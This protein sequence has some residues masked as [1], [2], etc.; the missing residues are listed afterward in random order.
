MISLIIG[1][2][3]A[4]VV[5][6]LTFKHPEKGP[7]SFGQACLINIAQFVIYIIYIIIVIITI[8]LLTKSVS[9]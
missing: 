9:A 4:T 2:F 1:F 3:V 8:D 5:Y 6:S 7:I